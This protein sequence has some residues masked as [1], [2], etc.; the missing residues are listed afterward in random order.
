MSDTT[1]E[2]NDTVATTTDELKA[3]I[4]E[5]EKALGSA[6]E[7]NNAEFEDLRERLREAVSDGQNML[8]NLTS[9]VRSQVRRADETIRANPYQTVGIATCL[10]IIA[11]YLLSRRLGHS[12]K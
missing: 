5:A 11:G 12:D 1:T 8:K 7:G 2:S 3:L 9:A 10:G 4:C 6:G